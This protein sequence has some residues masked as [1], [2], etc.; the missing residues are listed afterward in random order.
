LLQWQYKFNYESCDSY[1][2]MLKI[3]AK[4]FEYTSMLP[5]LLW[6]TSNEFALWS[7]FE[8]LLQYYPITYALV[9]QSNVL[10]QNSQ[11]CC[12]FLPY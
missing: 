1:I 10:S 5:S 11:K 7:I 2:N 12:I 8:D 6:T 9:V 4:Q 3:Y